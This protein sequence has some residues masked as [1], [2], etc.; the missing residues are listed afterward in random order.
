VLS[1]SAY[2]KFQLLARIAEGDEKAFRVLFDEYEGW[3]FSV[4]LK[5]TGSRSVAEEIFVIEN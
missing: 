3:F 4:V 1:P 2:S 5:M